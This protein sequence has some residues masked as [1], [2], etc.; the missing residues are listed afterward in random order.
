MLATADPPD[1][2]RQR[3]VLSRV[4]STGAIKAREREFRQLVDS[5]LE[6]HLPA[7]RV[8]WMGE[9]AEPLPIVMVTRLMGL[10]DTAAPAL[11]E[12]GYASVEQISG[13]VPEKRR[14]ALQEK[15]TELGPVVEGYMAARSA[16]DPDQSSVIG[17]CAHAVADG[18]LTD[19][20]AFG[21]TGI[22][23]AAGGEST[24]SLLASAPAPSPS[25]QIFR[26]ACGPSPP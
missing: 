18:E 12:Q 2:G 22:L 13:F 5:A 26:I 7:G 20:E 23:M 4:L 25:G 17:V 10:P 3:K 24:T 19:M 9:V 16:T 8:E 21:Q 11:K 15:M 14:Q 1:H 6:R